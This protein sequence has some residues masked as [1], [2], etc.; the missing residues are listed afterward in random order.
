MSDQLLRRRRLLHHRVSG[1]VHGR[2]VYRQHL[3]WRH[4][5]RG[6][7]TRVLCSIHLQ[8]RRERLHDEL[9]AE[10]RVLQWAVQR[11]PRGPRALPRAAW[12]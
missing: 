8:H 5:R 11:L 1:D 6:R 10:Q 9:L 12:D 7:F 3:R 4:M 2:D